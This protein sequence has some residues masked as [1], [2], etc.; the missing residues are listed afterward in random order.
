MVMK[1]R[2]L[3]VEDEA[4]IRELILFTLQ[5]HGFEATGADCGEDAWIQ[6]AKQTPELLVLDVLLPDMDGLSLCEM[7]RRIPQ[8]AKIP[9]LMLTACANIKTRHLAEH[10]GA[11]DFMSKPFSPRELAERV[12]RLLQT[13]LPLAA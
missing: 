12:Q 2:V 4:D 13:P 6:A 1:N 8:T 5:S 10:A 9:I 3:V 11:S 7:F